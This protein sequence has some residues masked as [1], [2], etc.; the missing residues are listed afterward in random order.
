[1]TKYKTASTVQVGE[2]CSISRGLRGKQVFWETMGVLLAKKV[3][4]KSVTLYFDTQPVRVEPDRVV[5][6]YHERE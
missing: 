3:N 6:V 5:L 1:M 2:W 4:S